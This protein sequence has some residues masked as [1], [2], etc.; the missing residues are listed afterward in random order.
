MTCLGGPNVVGMTQLRPSTA[1]AHVVTPSHREAV[2]LDVALAAVVAFIGLPSAIGFRSE[3]HNLA[4]GLLLDLGLSIPL[5]WRRRW[6]VEVFA[7]VAAVAFVQWLT[8]ERMLA[9]VALLVAFYTVAARSDLRKTV[10]AGVVLELGV[11]LATVQWSAGHSSSLVFVLLSGMTTAAFFIGT[12]MR[13]RRA[14]LASVEDRAA[15]LELERDQ[16]AQIAA[17]AERARIARDMHDIV[18]HNLSVMIALADGASLTAK[19]DPNRAG[20]AMH[21]VSATGR[22]AL[23]EMRRLLGILRED[24]SPALAPQ[25]GLADVDAL[26]AQVRIVGLRGELVTHGQPVHLSAGLQL[27]VYRLI[28]E[29]LTNTLKHAV[30]ATTSTVALR[31]GADQLDVV[32]TD[33]GAAARAG[34]SAGNPGHGI[35]G[36]SERAAAYGGTVE[37]GPCLGVGWR[38]CGRFDLAAQGVA[39]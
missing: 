21:Q 20:A 4:V 31:F 14:Y 16:Q 17:A 37:V 36:M 5:V 33:D 29:A 35:T 32:V 7:V 12:T 25:P 39:S 8:R 19:A 30:G 22:Q 3:G 34:E 10:L 23:T 2:L 24:Q 11:L 27:T 1:M 26:L 18:A 6:P 28:Q 38:V 13:T 15:R 9:D